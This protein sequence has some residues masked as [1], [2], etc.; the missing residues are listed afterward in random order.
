MLSVT[1]FGGVDEIGGNKFLIEDEKS[2][3]FLDFGLSFK[4]SNQFLDEF[5]NPRKFNG[6]IDYQELGLLPK[7]KGIYRTDY[8]KHTN[9]KDPVEELEFDALFLTHAHADHASYIHFLRKDL[10]FYG[11]KETFAILKSIEDCSNTA[12]TD[13][14]TFTNSFE[15]GS[16][17]EGKPKRL[18]SRDP[19]ILVP[20]SLNEIDSNKK[21]LIGDFE[22][23]P[24]LVN[25]SL[26]GACAYLIHSPEADIAFSGDI[27][28]HGKS[29]FLTENFAKKARNVKYLMIEGTRIDNQNVKSELDVQ[30]EISK[31]IRETSGLVVANWPSRDTDRL[32]S[33]FNAAVE[34]DRV[35]VISSKQAYLLNQLSQ[36]GADVPSIDNKN[37]RIFIQRRSWGL[38]GISDQKDQILKDYS[39]VKWEAG[40]LDHSNMVT[41]KD[42]QTDYSRYV[43]RAD[44][45]DMTDLIDIRPPPNSSYIRSMV[46]PFDDEMLVSEQKLDNWLHH[47]KLKKF[48]THC[49]G[50]APSPDLIKIIE[51][52]EPEFVIPIHTTNAQKFKELG[53]NCLFLSSGVSKKL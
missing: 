24:V 15:I 16:T 33:F 6:L 13:L 21:T 35:L 31:I 4:T 12:N 40:F 43:F 22:I 5:L 32:W 18:D 47:F 11:T 45:F 28:L 3:I 52:I 17:K 27:R 9:P 41:F 8:Q 39:F 36:S 44:L 49:S 42:I 46:E 25:H 26:L 19:G 48:Q 1:G 2:R 50:H 37:I 10:P 30:N 34:N 38:L 51:L 53:F 20:R 14:C 7:I 23:E 29:G